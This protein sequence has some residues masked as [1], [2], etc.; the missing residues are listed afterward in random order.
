MII[1]IAKKLRDGAEALAQWHSANEQGAG[2]AVNA[3]ELDPRP[4]LS[5]TTGPLT[6]LWKKNSI[7]YEF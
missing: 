5:E 3:D 1:P 4:V 7:R 6:V 2:R